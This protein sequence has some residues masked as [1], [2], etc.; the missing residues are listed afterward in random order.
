V[1]ELAASPGLVHTA[2]A[3][4]QRYTIGSHRV[5]VAVGSEVRF[6]RAT[7]DDS[8]LTL[9]TG[10]VTCEVA[11]LAP[12]GS[13]RVLTRDGAVRV[14]GTQFVVDAGD[15]CT[16]VTVLKGTVWLEGHGGA[17]VSAPELAAGQEGTICPPAAQPT[18]AAGDDGRSA[19]QEALELISNGKEPERAAAL[20]S[21]YLDDHPRGLFEEEALFYL[22][23]LKKNLGHPEDARHLADRFRAAFPQSRRAAELNELLGRTPATDDRP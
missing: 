11:P 18:A 8:T 9:K 19:V 7:Q 4:A 22:C 15:G 23:I 13:F 12:R 1:A 2:L 10:R 14:V 5:D 6:D 16:H 17:A 21:R 20:L 3:P